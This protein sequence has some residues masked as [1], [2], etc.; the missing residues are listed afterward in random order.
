[1]Q[2]TS[3]QLRADRPPMGRPPPL[4]QTAAAERPAQPDA[5]ES[6]PA[7]K[8]PK[9]VKKPKQRAA[10]LLNVG[11]KQVW[12]ALTTLPT[13]ETET[14]AQPTWPE[15]LAAQGE[16]LY[17][18]AC[19]AQYD[20][21]G[22][23]AVLRA[24]RL[25]LAAGLDN[26]GWLDYLDNKLHSAVRLLSMGNQEFTSE[27]EDWM[28]EGRKRGQKRQRSGAAMPAGL[29]LFPRMAAL[30][31]LN[32]AFWDLGRR[33]G[34][35]MV[36][37]V[38]LANAVQ[39]VS[40]QLPGV[41][42]AL[43]DILGHKGAKQIC[44]SW[45]VSPNWLRKKGAEGKPFRR[46]GCTLLQLLRARWCEAAGLVARAEKDHVLDAANS[47]TRSALLAWQYIGRD[48]GAR[49]MALVMPSTKALIKLASGARKNGLVEL[50]AGNG[51]WARLLAEEKVAVHALDVDPPELPSPGAV[52]KMGT[53][54][55]LAGVQ[56]QTLLICMPP[57][58]ED[59]CSTSALDHFKGDRVAYVGE[60]NSGMTA[61]P[62]FHEKLLQQFELT[63]RIPLPNWPMM[64]A[65]MFL[66]R[67]LAEPSSKEAGKTL[68]QC[69]VCGNFASKEGLW[70]CPWSRQFV[71]CSQACYDKS[72]DE[73][74]ALLR[75]VYAGAKVSDRP[76]FDEWEPV[77]WFD[78][79]T[80]GPGTGRRWNNLKAATPQAELQPKGW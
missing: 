42:D 20:L 61:T 55:D 11:G 69:D 26:E 63:K 53:A 47:R 24:L 59:D 4:L 68:Q 79:E 6:T 18:A 45:G 2:V 32:F 21:P 75:V 40:L 52:V 70:R 10:D 15:V 58:G 34:V 72:E 51:Y 66:F 8:P 19:K 23:I 7:R 78:Q 76:P 36:H 39:A 31:R 1:M 65:E 62:R 73:H 29:K 37:P 33:K 41:V 64:R 46:G 28:K 57:P 14:P 44:R 50:G 5:V 22:A 67:R 16:E 3:V 38:K 9:R 80:E 35:K 25:C 56:E 27:A 74:K 17:T 43:R 48:C 30:D 77:D 54:K 60:W 12:H 49:W 71:C 13:D